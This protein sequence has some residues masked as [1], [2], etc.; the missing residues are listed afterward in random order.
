M[1]AHGIFAFST[2]RASA[3]V[4]GFVAFPHHGQGIGFASSVIGRPSR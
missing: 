3:S 2:L 1:K 4:I